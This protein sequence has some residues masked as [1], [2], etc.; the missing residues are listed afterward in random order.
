MR[1]SEAWARSTSTV[2]PCAHL[3]G[4]ALNRIDLA[5]E[6]ADGTEDPVDVSGCR[7][8]LARRSEGRRSTKGFSCCCTSK[9]RI[10]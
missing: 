3:L 1:I 5:I 7:Q 2:I 10:G 4:F 8:G 6:A 9:S